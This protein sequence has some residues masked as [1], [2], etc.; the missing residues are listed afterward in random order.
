MKIGDFSGATQTGLRL[1]AYEVLNDDM[2]FD[3][4]TTPESWAWIYFLLRASPDRPE[5]FP[6]GY[7]ATLQVIEARLL[8]EAAAEMVHP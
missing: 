6:K 5:W 3:H 7:S 8:K 4:I 1:W 2:A